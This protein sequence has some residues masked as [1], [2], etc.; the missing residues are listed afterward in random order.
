[1]SAAEE[2][3][4]G[5]YG[6]SAWFLAH[7]RGEAP[8]KHLSGLINEM[9]MRQGT[10]LENTRKCI[11]IF[12]WGGDA[13]DLE[14][15]DDPD[16]ETMCNT[17][18]AAKNVVETTHAKVCKSRI[19]PMPL[20]SGGGYLARYEAKQLGK[21]LEGEF[22][23]NDLDQIK[24]DVVMDALVT[25]HGAGAAKVF[26]KNGRPCVE[27]VPIEDVWFDAAETRQR[28]PS[29]CYHVMNEDMFRALAEYGKDEP[30]LH[31]T[32]EERRIGIRRAGAATVIRRVNSA[33]GP[34]RIEIIEAWHK[35]SGGCS[36]DE[37]DG[38]SITV[39]DEE[40][41]AVESAEYSHD[42]RHTIIVD[43]CTLVDEPWD[44]SD[45][46]IEFYVPRKRRRSIWGMSMMFDLV[47]PQREFEKVTLKIQNQHQKMGVSQWAAPVGAQM[48][49]REIV[50]GTFAAGAVM[51]YT[52]QVPP[53]PLVVEPVAQ[54][55]YA[56]QDSIPRNMMQY[57]GISQLSATSQLPAGMGD[58]SGK[59]LQV[60]ED[61]EAE[62]LLCYH[63][64]LERWTIRI[65]WRIVD[66]AYRILK[67][68]KNPTVKYQGKRGFENLKW[69]DVLPKKKALLILRVFPVSQLS[70]QP[71]ARFAQLQELLN[72]GAITV[73]Q[74]KRLYEM[75]DLE[76]ENEL[77]S[78]D[79]D[80]IDRTMDVMITTGR[81]I[82]PEPTDDFPLLLKRAG[83]MINLCRAQEVPDGR[84]KL[85]RD[86]I[87]DTK[88]LMER[89]AEEERK[90]AAEAAARAQPT[91]P[92]PGMPMPGAPP[93]MPP[94]MP[95]MPV[96][97]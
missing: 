73:E 28:R 7:E 95:P 78:S 55:T 85:L 32:A 60:F 20:T 6:D 38:E 4:A 39:E 11:N 30:D 79:T 61:F 23:E 16:L 68:G 14:D 74:F 62:R 1:M 91:P 54:G 50:A 51:E 75:P 84:I 46:P 37:E 71:S 87:E 9:R 90:K 49:A 22:D 59:A 89:I 3:Y 10:L 36:E 43:G 69:A 72:A 34:C 17:Y 2:T 21:A 97:A 52:G 66:C 35:P 53:T 56:Y 88:T 93:P 19:L 81:Y 47:A 94:G 96:A 77:D 26:E 65:A 57:Q 41:N 44:G 18:N 27:F 42:G 12:Q 29:C 15:T 13:R 63:R 31:G 70:K 64:E 48:N 76:A 80:I 8:D 24:E 67:S 33:R 92:P 83:K 82:G 40:G 25:A 45:F 58:A 86:Y 5:Q